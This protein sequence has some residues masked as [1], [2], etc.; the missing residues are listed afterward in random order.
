MQ[1]CAKLESS[2][3]KC[4]EKESTSPLGEQAMDNYA[5]IWIVNSSNG[6]V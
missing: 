6:D 5:Q 2:V 4:E 1:F 3:M